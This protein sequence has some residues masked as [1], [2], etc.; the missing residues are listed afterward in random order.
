MIPVLGKRE[1]FFFFPE[2]ELLGKKGEG[3][4]FGFTNKLAL[5]NIKNV[6]SVKTYNQKVLVS[7]RFSQMLLMPQGGICRCFGF[8]SVSSTKLFGFLN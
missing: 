7:C 4:C 6:T 8:I 1:F 2:T 5:I 3:L